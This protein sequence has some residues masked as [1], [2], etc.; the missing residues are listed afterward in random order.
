MKSMSFLR[1]HKA[2]E[3]FTHVFIPFAVMFTGYL[4][5][6][7]YDWTKQVEV[8]PQIINVKTKDS[9][10]NKQIES[11]QG[12]LTDTLVLLPK[13]VT[14]KGNFKGAWKKLKDFPGS[15]RLENCCFTINDKAYVGL[16]IVGDI[17][18]SDLWEYDVKNDE[19]NKKPRF[20]G[21]ARSGMFYF[22][23]NDKAY[24]GGGYGKK[25]IN[26]DYEYKEYF[27]QDFWQYS[28]ENNSWTKKKY[29]P[30]DYALI[31]AVSFVIDGKG[32]VATG[33]PRGRCMSLKE[34]Y[35][36]DPETDNWTKKNNFPG[37]ER[38]L[39]F[40]FTLNGKGYVGGGKNYAH[41][42]YSDFWEY[43]PVTDRWTQ[44]NNFP[45]KIE[46][47]KSI[48]INGKVYVGFGGYYPKGNI[49]YL[50]DLWEYNPEK[51]SWKTTLK[52]IGNP[53]V[54]NFLFS[55]RNKGYIG[56]GY[57]Y[58]KNH[59]WHYCGDI[60]EFTPPYTTVTVPDKHLKK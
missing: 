52:F 2:W 6:K 34:L 19:W 39:A 40:A 54:S 45:V 3:W 9:L 7:H 15:K 31:D 43:D 35:E 59:D 48:V 46:S 8:K 21:D 30:I 13:N 12:E 25:R 4:L 5:D 16:G 47:A 23:I 44:K 57:N 56:L 29:L 50:S 42:T 1:S 49:L 27:T 17:F 20:P 36:Y 10:D 51:D 14:V 32:Y 55:I 11:I 18:L 41:K 37:E 22:V 58:N 60:W 28:P 26:S 33:G 24:I 38:T 53:R